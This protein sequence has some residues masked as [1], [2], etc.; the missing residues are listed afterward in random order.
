[1]L[2][3]PARSVPDALFT[4]TLKRATEVAGELGR[5][6]ALDPR[7]AD[8]AR[9]ID[10]GDFEGMP[11]RRLQR[12]FPDLWARNEAEREDSFAWPGGE[13]YAHFRDRVLGGL[14]NAAASFPDRRVAVVTH[15]GVIAQVLG[16][17]KGRRACVWKPDRPGPLTATE[18]LWENGAPRA[19]LRFSDPDWY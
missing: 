5:V 6:W 16:V 17:V 18:V 1:M 12:E 3:R 14:S 7:G 4:S 15:A 8:W 11:L 10:C 13:T 19:V 2:R 9:E